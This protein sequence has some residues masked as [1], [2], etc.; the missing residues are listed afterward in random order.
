MTSWSV[1][2]NDGWNRCEVDLLSNCLLDGE[3]LIRS[4]VRIEGR[5]W[6]RESVVETSAEL[7]D[8]FSVQL[9]QVLLRGGALQQFGEALGDWLSCRQGF[10][11]ELSGVKGQSLE[12]CIGVRD[13]LI[14][15]VEK[16]ALTVRYGGERMRSAEWFFL[17]DETCI[18]RLKVELTRSLSSLKPSAD[19]AA[20]L[21]P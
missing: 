15:T 8:D 18:A 17:V 19:P 3:E 16:P 11:L 21:D 14:C 4:R 1:V 2:S 12:F 20:G 13:D 9:S 10:S 6:R 5:F 7:V